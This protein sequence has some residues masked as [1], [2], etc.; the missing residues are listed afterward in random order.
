MKQAKTILQTL[1]LSLAMTVAGMGAAHGAVSA[2]EAKQLGATLTP[3]GAEKAGNKDGTI[4]A[5][6][7]A[8]VKGPG[9]AKDGKLANPFAGEKPLISITAANAQQYRDKLTDGAVELLRRYPGYRMDVYPTHR[10]FPELTAEFREASIKNASNPDC[11]LTPD[12]VGMRGCWAGVPFPIPK[13]GA[14]IIWNHIVRFRPTAEY[15]AES[16]LISPNSETQLNISRAYMEFPYHV[17]EVRAYDGAGQYYSRFVNE[18]VGP[19]RDVGNVTMIHYPI[20]FDRL[21]QRA[22][23]YTPGQ[24]RVRLAPEFAYDTPSASMGGAMNYD[25]IG[26]FSGRLDRY[27][28]KLIGKKEKYVAS[29]GYDFIFGTNRAKL[30]GK[31]Y[32]NPDATRWEL[33]RVWVVEATLKQGRRHAVPKRTFY[34]DEDSWTIVAAEAYDGA[35]KL[36]RVQDQYT[37]PDYTNNSWVSTA[38]FVSYDLSKEQYAA[39]NMIGVNPGGFWKVLAQR[40]P[41]RSLMP[42]ALSRNGLR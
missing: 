41:D 13:S 21:D 18:S 26:L 35:N 38:F 22:W 39:I 19:A 40:R 8:P 32:V 34:V 17:P 30:L 15:Q 2:E 36:V 24:R 9:A 37:A 29:N 6:T 14:E 23:S 33:R 10:T 3:W 25:E 27:D 28:F 16:W 1:S 5:Y 12:T 4:P 20:E 7:G 11:K 42:E 31:Q